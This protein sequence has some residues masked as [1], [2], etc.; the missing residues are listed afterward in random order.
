MHTPLLIEI[1]SSPKERLH[2]CLRS[3]GAGLVGRWWSDPVD[4]WPDPVSPWVAIPFS[5]RDA[6]SLGFL[7][8][9]L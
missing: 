1:P 4:F 2:G 9:R 7:A 6:P 3:N 5:V 8:G